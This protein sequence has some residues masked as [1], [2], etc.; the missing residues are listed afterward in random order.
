MLL[1]RAFVAFQK[2]SE[3]TVG[4]DGRRPLYARSKRITDVASTEAATSNRS[5]A[6]RSSR[7]PALMQKA[8]TKQT[9]RLYPHMYRVQHKCIR[10]T[11]V[12]VTFCLAAT[13]RN[14]Q[15]PIK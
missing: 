5:A 1:N 6:G 7:A 3:V 12:L 2:F 13:V 4:T 15:N 8:E 9:S 10:T 14:S 11:A